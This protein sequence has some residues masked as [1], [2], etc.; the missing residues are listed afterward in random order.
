MQVICPTG[1]SANLLSGTTI[2]KFLKVPSGRDAG[3]DMSPPQGTRSGQLQDNLD[4]IQCLHIDDRSLVGCPTLGWMEYLCTYGKA[5]I[6]TEWGGIPVLTTY[7][8]D[9]QLPPVCDSPVYI[10][11]TSTSA[12]L[13]GT[14]VWEGFDSVACLQKVIRQMKIKMNLKVFWSLLETIQLPLN[15]YV[16][17]NSF[18]GT[19]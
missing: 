8:D 10:G 2:H 5:N 11:K 9:G 4:S 19:T 18:S 17:S 16:G 13:H 6:S 1:N 7:G 15:N 14:K 3:K 12:G